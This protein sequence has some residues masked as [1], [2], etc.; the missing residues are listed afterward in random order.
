MP[1]DPR[2]DDSRN[3]DS[4]NNDSRKD[5]RPERDASRDG[6]DD[7]SGLSLQ[8]PPIRLPSFF[9]EDFRV[10]WPGGGDDP[11]RRAVSAR[12]V[13][14]ACVAFDAADALLALTVDAPLVTGVRTVGGALAAAGTFGLLGLPYLCEPVAALLGLGTLTVFPSL[15]ALLVV[16]GLR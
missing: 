4:R 12:T 5:D 16:R 7:S 9:P 11:H 13:A 10:L 8:L 6:T 1:D 14:L 15:S 3:N 2:S